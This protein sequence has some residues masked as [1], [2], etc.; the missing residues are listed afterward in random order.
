VFQ[1]KK[2]Q[3]KTVTALKALRVCQHCADKALV[4]VAIA[5]DIIW[6]WKIAKKIKKNY[7]KLIFNTLSFFFYF[8]DITTFSVYCA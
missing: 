3:C 2:Q 8:R 4:K 1:C 7:Q 5:H 6:V